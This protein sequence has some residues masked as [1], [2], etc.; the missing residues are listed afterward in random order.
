MI[1]GART[2]GR[3][4]AEGK[5]A[6][7]PGEAIVPATACDKLRI[8]L[9][10]LLTT[11]AVAAPVD[12]VTAGALE[13][14]TPAQLAAMLLPPADA[15]RIVDGRI[16]LIAFTLGYTVEVWERSVPVAPTICRRP[17]H[18]RLYFDQSS[19]GRYG[20]PSV[21]LISVSGTESRDS[22]GTTY[23]DRAT[24]ERCA[25]LT[26]YL[27]GSPLRAASMIQALTRVTEAMRAA[28][29]PGA[30][31]FTL[32]CR[33]DHGEQPCTNERTALA[34]LP[35]DALMGVAFNR[36]HPARPGEAPPAPGEPDPPTLEFG[37][38]A[39]HGESWFVTLIGGAD[40]LREVVMWRT[41]VIYH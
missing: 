32:R 22:Y 15:A 13:H 20:D 29:A 11:A 38:A 40:G 36:D 5:D 16:H 37:M 8:M 33:D 35:L 31:P 23:P 25:A 30:L 1:E 4:C 2:I 27:G 14:A 6:A 3:A 34:S 9:V 19:L 41:M 12:R 17:A 26:H 10:F 21:V 28:A 7:P 39:P 24:P 18:T